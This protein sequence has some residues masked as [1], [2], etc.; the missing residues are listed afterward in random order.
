MV[1]AGDIRPTSA[2]YH[3][4]DGVAADTWRRN[5]DPSHDAYPGATLRFSS[6]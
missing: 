6:G 4:A 3:G 1:T 5:I 2:T